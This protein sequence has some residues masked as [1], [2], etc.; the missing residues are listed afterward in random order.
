MVDYFV[1]DGNSPVRIVA[2]PEAGYKVVGASVSGGSSVD[3][4]LAAVEENTYEIPAGAIPAGGH[5]YVEVVTS[6][7][8]VEVPAADAVVN[9]LR[10]NYASVSIVSGV[11]TDDSGDYHWDGSDDIVL[12]AVGYTN[13]KVDKLT[14][15]ASTGASGELTKNDNGQFVLSK[16]SVEIVDGMAIDISAD[17]S[18]NGTVLMECE[19]DSALVDVELDGSAWDGSMF[20][21]AGDKDVVVFVTAKSDCAIDEVVGNCS[22]L[23]GALVESEPGVYRFSKSLYYNSENGFPEPGMPA[24]ELNDTINISI[25]AHSIKQIPAVSISMV[26]VEIE[27]YETPVTEMRVESGTEKNDEDVLMWNGDD[28]IVI[29]CHT[30]PEFVVDEISYVASNNHTGTL[31]QDSDGNYVMPM[32]EF[33]ES[34]DFSIEFTASVKFGGEIT[35]DASFASDA[36]SVKLNGEE[37]DGS[38]YVWAGRD[39]LVLVVEPNEGYEV[40]GVSADGIIWNGDMLEIEPDSHTYVIPRSVLFFPE[41]SVESGVPFE[42]S[43]G[44]THIEVTTTALERQVLVHF[45]YE[46][47]TIEPI[48]AMQAVESDSTSYYWTHDDSLQFRVTPDEGFEIE[49]VVSDMSDDEGNDIVVASESDPDVFVIDQKAL[50]FSADKEFNVFVTVKEL[51]P[52]YTPIAAFELDCEGAELGR[53]D[54]SGKGFYGYGGDEDPAVIVENGKFCSWEAVNDVPVIVEI[55]PTWDGENPVDFFA[56]PAEGY[57][58]SEVYVEC[59]G[60]SMSIKPDDNNQ[61][62]IPVADIIDPDRDDNLIVIHFV[63]E[64]IPDVKVEFDIVNSRLTGITGINQVGVD[65]YWDGISDIDFAA[66]ALEGFRLV[67]VRASGCGIDS[68]LEPS[69]ENGDHYTV[70]ASEIN[71][72]EEETPVLSIQVV[73]EEIL[74]PYDI[75]IDFDVHNAL[76]PSV[77]GVKQEGMQYKWDRK[78]DITFSVVPN[79]GYQLAR[80]TITG[81]S[82]DAIYEEPAELYII[83]VGSIAPAG[84]TGV[85]VITVETE[86]ILPE[87]DVAVGFEV[88]SATANSIQGVVRV[89][90][91]LMWDGESD[92]SFYANPMNGYKITEVT[93]TGCTDITE[94]VPDELGCYVL[95]ASAINPIEGAENSIYIVVETEQLPPEHEV[96]VKF[97]LNG[98]GASNIRGLI[99]VDDEF[100]WNG[101]DNITFTVDVP[102]GVEF[103]SAYVSGAGLDGYLPYGKELYFVIYKEDIVDNGFL[104]TIEITLTGHEIPVETSTKVNFVLNGVGVEEITGVVR[105]GDDLYWNS[106]DS[107]TFVAQPIEGIRLNSVTV[108]GCGLNKELNELLDGSNRYAIDAAEIQPADSSDALTITFN[109]EEIVIPPDADITVA[110]SAMNVSVSKI[111]GVTQENNQFKWNCTSDISFTVAPKAGYQLDSVH[112]SGCGIDRDLEGSNGSYVIPA[113]EIVVGPEGTGTISI[114]IKTSAASDENGVNVKFVVVNA[115][116][117]SI[118]G[119]AIDEDNNFTWNEVDDITFIP[120]AHEGYVIESITASGCG[121]ERALSEIGAGTGIYCVPAEEINPSGTQ[122]ETLTITV[123]TAVQEENPDEPGDSAVTLQINAEYSYVNNF[124]GLTVSGKDI[125][126]DESEGVYKA[127]V[128]V[129]GFN[130]LVIGEYTP[131]WDGSSDISFT[132]YPESGYAFDSIVVDSTG[133]TLPEEIE[134]LG[135]NS[136]R[137]SGSGINVSSSNPV[138][139]INVY[140]VDAPPIEIDPSEDRYVFVTGNGVNIRNDAGTSGTTVIGTAYTGDYFHYLGSKEVNGKVWYSFVYQTNQV[141][142]ISSDYASVEDNPPVTGIDEID[143]LAS[144]YKVR[145]M[146]I[147]LIEDGEVTDAYSYGYATK[148]TDVMTNEHNVRVASLSKVIVGMA[149]MKMQEEGLVDLNE[150]IGTYWDATVENPNYPSN[151][152]TLKTLLSHTSSLSSMDCNNV[153]EQITSSSSYRNVRPGSSGAWAYNNFGLDVAGATLEMAADRTLDSYIKEKFHSGLDIDATFTPGTLQD[154]KYAT[155]YYSGGS[156]ARTAEAQANNLSIAEPGS[157][158]N[159]QYFAGGWTGSATDYAKM[160]AIL[161]NDGEYGGTRY[162]SEESVAQIESQLF[163]TTEHGGDFEQCLPLRHKENYLGQDEVFYHTGNAY[164]L[165]ALASYNPETRNGVVVLAIGGSDTRDEQGVYASCSSISEY[166]YENLLSLG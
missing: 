67:E 44:N 28:S 126:W 98:V 7:Q 81:C 96:R 110:F 130:G 65:Y 157:A 162:L 13:F 64:P 91:N 41:S 156:V 25:A 160:L 111:S 35:L 71:P 40:S 143:A 159:A 62:I 112:V 16:D 73:V 54:F 32:A 139:T 58:I 137:I 113:S 102:D 17:T 42:Y 97:I 100:M 135:S 86:A 141:G 140:C 68:V 145:S 151:P 39:D 56:E 148:D 59:N 30:R 76:L 89:D 127:P 52:V 107:I 61:Y 8:D 51:P 15:E 134:E 37:W 114:A 150:G 48:A 49:K 20:E 104:P 154:K 5:L 4:A 34:E 118:T 74:S 144:Q 84:D 108:S 88:H 128:T 121:M 158:T 11:A 18:F 80:V 165:L 146:Q 27:G 77:T 50:T 9:L 122:P 129:E 105:D 95:P 87:Q 47:C 153:L 119:V 10:D 63:T 45:N 161:V 55:Q 92:I 142:W 103:D 46:N 24:P 132:V 53:V 133:C 85:I 166:C 3:G 22:V 75:T 131:T 43:S 124:S 38:Q 115:S 72:F 57:I 90:G 136:F 109:T 70:Y 79:D 23:S 69:G 125:Q 60:D 19:Y 116:V 147:A 138:I 78:S 31:D 29:A 14:Y 93:V 2:A 163:T 106:K 26:D 94:L 152:I 155:L 149:T 123:S 33:A 101:Y 36:V 83:P 6:K 82:A 99:S 12:A 1:W 21:W 117:S 164:G 120:E 66:E